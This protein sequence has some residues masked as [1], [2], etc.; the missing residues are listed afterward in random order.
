MFSKSVKK[1][2]H[3]TW[4]VSRTR[5]S[6][7][8]VDG[9]R[10]GRVDLLQE[11]RRTMKGLAQ[12]IYMDTASCSA[13]GSAALK[14]NCYGNRALV[15][16]LAGIDCDM[17]E[18]GSDDLVLGSGL[19]PWSHTIALHVLLNLGVK[20]VLMCLD[21]LRLPSCARTPHF[22]TERHADTLLSHS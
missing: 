14:R 19:C 4:L 9:F 8:S 7:D 17:S 21:S 18:L 22:S 11:G 13:L 1:G 20:A 16:C 3:C 10:L 2:L 6:S 15:W 5:A 12:S